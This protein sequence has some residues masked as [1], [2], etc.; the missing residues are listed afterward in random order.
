MSNLDPAQETRLCLF[1]LFL[2]FLGLR[3]G[4][5]IHWS[6]WWVTAPLWATAALGLV[7]LAIGKI[8]EVIGRLLESEQAK[9]N[10]KAR[11]ALENYSRS[12]RIPRQPR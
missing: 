3:L 11:E 2:L 5:A 10:R 8:L 12:L 4:G 1:A 7:L 6:Y 9:K